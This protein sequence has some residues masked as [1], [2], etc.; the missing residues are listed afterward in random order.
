[1]LPTKPFTVDDKNYMGFDLSSRPVEEFPA[2]IK[3]YCFAQE[4]SIDDVVTEGKRVLPAGLT[5]VEFIDCN[6]DN[7]FIPPGN[8][9]TRGSNKLIQIKNDLMDWVLDNATKLPTE[10]SNLKRANLMGLN[11][12]PLQIPVERQ[13]E[14]ALKVKQDGLDAIKEAAFKTAK[15]TFE[16]VV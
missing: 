13:A 5:G 14:S 9:V 4:F 3:N 10:P 15:D 7:V 8:T 2:V 16:G 1:M 11:T 6:L 12:D